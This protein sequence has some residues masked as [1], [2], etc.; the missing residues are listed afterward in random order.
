MF[1]VLGSVCRFYA[2]VQQESTPSVG[3]RLYLS[4]FSGKLWFLVLLNLLGTT[5]LL[6]VLQRCGQSVGTEDHGRSFSVGDSLICVFGIW[7]QQGKERIFVC[8]IDML[9]FCSLSIVRFKRSDTLTRIELWNR[10]MLAFRQS[11]DE[12]MGILTSIYSQIK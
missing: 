11:L 8:C 6:T 4:P 12:K 10:T 1:P 7:C 5:F 9:Q 3:W 2:V